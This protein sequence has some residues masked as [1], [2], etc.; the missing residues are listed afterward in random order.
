MKIMGANRVVGGILALA[1]AA[2]MLIPILPDISLYFA[3]FSVDVMSGLL[4]LISFILIILALVGGI[5]ALAGKKAGGI[6]A[7]IAGLVFVILGILVAVSP[8][9][10][11]GPVGLMW[12]FSWGTTTIYLGL[13][14]VL[15]I[16]M[17]LETILVLVGGIIAIPGE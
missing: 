17:S 4:F 15:Y 6:L 13:P 10:L 9:L 2:L 1:G 8:M 7:L 12:I 5:V 11:L 3:L 16:Y 14:L